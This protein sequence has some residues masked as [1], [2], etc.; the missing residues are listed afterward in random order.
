MSGIGKPPHRAVQEYFDQ[1][2]EGYLS[3]STAT[4]GS[5]RSEIFQERRQRVL[6]VMHEPVGRVLDIG[7]G[8]GV[9]TK[10]LLD[11][12]GECWILDLSPRMVA[13]GRERLA[14]DP[15]AHR[16]HYAVADLERLPFGDRLFDTVLCIGVLQYLATPDVA[17]RELARVTRHGG[18]VIVSFPN[19]R[20]P[21]NSLQRAIV[22]SLR[23][24]QAI[25][26]RLGM[27]LHPP[28]SRLTF[29]D[30]I[31]N[32]SFAQDQMEAMARQVGLQPQ[33]VV[34]HSVHFPFSIPGLHV[35]LRAWDR[36]A[37]R[38][39]RTGRFTMWGREIL[40]RFHCAR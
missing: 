13:A 11:R 7:S 35:L 34:Y 36:L 29:R 33:G 22:R 17:L 18:Q 19:Q 10:A 37:N 14:G 16:L 38:A 9:F 5:A 12:G 26:R 30:D 4:T 6:D 31:P 8:P 23:G 15:A 21:L 2:V 1:D 39:F 3:A 25:L 20:S 24:G 40:M 28:S 32:A 27:E